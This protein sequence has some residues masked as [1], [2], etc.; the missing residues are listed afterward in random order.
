[1]RVQGDVEEDE[2]I[3]DKE[4]DIK[5]RFHRARSHTQKHTEQGGGDGNGADSDE[6]YVCLLSLF[7]PKLFLTSVICYHVLFARCF[8]VSTCSVLRTCKLTIVLQLGIG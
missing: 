8:S 3:A 6:E 7:I 1:M 5:P 2:H 4:S